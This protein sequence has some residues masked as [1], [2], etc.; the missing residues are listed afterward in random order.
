MTIPQQNYLV[1]NLLSFRQSN[2]IMG[3]NSVTYA[4]C[5]IC[6]GTSMQGRTQQISKGGG[7]FKKTLISHLGTDPEN[8]GGEGMKIELG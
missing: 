6:T 4:V 5:L 2:V 1:L 7:G 8:F 3:Q